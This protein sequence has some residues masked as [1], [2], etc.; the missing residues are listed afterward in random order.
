[1]GLYGYVNSKIVARTDPTGLLPPSPCLGVCSGGDRI[2]IIPP[3]YGTPPNGATCV[4]QSTDLRSCLTCCEY[5]EQSLLGCAQACG[6]VY[7]NPD[8]SPGSGP[9]DDCKF[10][11]QP[12]LSDEEMCGRYKQHCKIG[13]SGGGTICRGGR[14][15]SCSWPRNWKPNVPQ[16]ARN[17]YDRCIIANEDTHHDDIDCN[18]CNG[19]VCRPG[20]RRGVNKRQQECISDIASITCFRS[21]LTECESL[22]EPDRG[23]CISTVTYLLRLSCAAAQ[24]D[25][26]AQPIDCP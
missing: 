13:K 1:M 2:G 24:Q 3:P 8:L 14:A 19:S 26:G 11:D 17:I 12:G 4:A 25:C 9:I 7:Q 16:L 22:S 15:V 21:G 6:H 18:D 20:F 5:G 23:V 10:S